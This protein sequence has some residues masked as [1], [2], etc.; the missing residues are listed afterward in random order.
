MHASGAT[1][2]DIYIPVSNRQHLASRELVS[3]DHFFHAGRVWFP[4]IAV[5]R[6]QTIRKYPVI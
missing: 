1:G 2:Q 3:G 6:R 4:G 5:V